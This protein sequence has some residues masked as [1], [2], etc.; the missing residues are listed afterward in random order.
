MGL[1]FGGIG[2]CTC[3]GWLI[4]RRRVACS[5]R[6]RQ[7][8]PSTG[9]LLTRSCAAKPY[10]WH[11]GQP[12]QAT[13]YRVNVRIKGPRPPPIGLTCA[14]TSARA[15][16]TT[17]QSNFACNS[18]ATISTFEIPALKLQRFQT[19]L[20][21]HPTEL[22]AKFGGGGLGAAPRHRGWALF[23]SRTLEPLYRPR[24][25]RPRVATTN[26]FT[27]NRCNH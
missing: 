20:N 14:V 7:P 11:G 3:V 25:P 16:T 24:Q 27:K 6:S 17:N 2:G 4:L 15:A 8:G 23:R 21:I 22:H 13:T 12:A 5:L 9:T 1:H 10:G 26:S 19:L 18:P